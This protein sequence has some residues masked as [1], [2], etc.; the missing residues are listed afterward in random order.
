MAYGVYIYMTYS[1]LKKGFTASNIGHYSIE[2]CSGNSNRM[3]FV[4]LQ[5]AASYPSPKVR[6]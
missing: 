2:M 4:V 5:R 1:A 6:N 3:L